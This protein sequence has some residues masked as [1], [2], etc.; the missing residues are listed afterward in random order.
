MELTV[1]PMAANISVNGLTITC[2]AEVSTHGKTD[3]RTKA[4]TLM[5]KRQGSG[6]TRG[7]MDVN[8]MAS[9][10]TG[11]SMVK[12]NTFCRRE[13]REG[14]P[15]AKVNVKSGSMPQAYLRKTQ[16]AQEKVFVPSKVHKSCPLK[17]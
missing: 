10:K 14:A 11:S 7:L 6:S 3:V 4:S 13:C 8:I 1:G 17:L 16:L 2:M 15:G 5:I 9:G 12:G